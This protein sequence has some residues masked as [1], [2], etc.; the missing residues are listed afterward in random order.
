M[1]SDSA[2]SAG[3]FDQVEGIVTKS[4]AIQLFQNVCLLVN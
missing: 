4:S 3:D 1:N 2:M